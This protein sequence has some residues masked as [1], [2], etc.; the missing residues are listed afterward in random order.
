M[1]VSVLA[2]LLNVCLFLSGIFF[3]FFM[4]GFGRYFGTFPAVLAAAAGVYSSL[5]CY[6]VGLFPMNR[7]SWHMV[8]AMS[9]FY[10]GLLTIVLFAVTAAFDPQKRLPN[11]FIVFAI[12]ETLVF[13]AFLL[14]PRLGGKV[15]SLDPSVSER[16][17]LWMLPILEWL[18]MVGI[19][20]W[21]LSVSF[22][23]F[24]YDKIY[25]KVAF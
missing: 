6:A 21:I 1:K 22:F 4:V 13:A 24:H 18:V 17:K 3:T 19:A 11:V 25:M 2:R 8:S 9:F 10:G 16:P 23:I 7:M 12:V 14:L 5:A 15:F 20:G